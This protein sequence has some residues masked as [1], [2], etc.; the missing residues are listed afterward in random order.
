MNATASFNTI[1]SLL[2]PSDSAPGSLGGIVYYPGGTYHSIGRS[3]YPINVGL[4]P[5]ATSGASGATNGV[6]YFPTYSIWL[7]NGYGAPPTSTG[8]ISS[9]L[10]AEQLISYNSFVD[11]TSKTVMVSEWQKGT[12]IQP[13]VP[14]GSSTLGNVF[15]I[16]DTSTT[17]TGT[18]SPNQASQPYPDYA[19]AQD[20]Q[21]QTPNASQW[22]WKGDWWIL[23]LA[24]LTLTLSCRIGI[25]AGIPISARGREPS[26]WSLPHRIIRE[27]STRCS[28]TDLCDSSKARFLPRYGMRS[29][30]L[31]DVRPSTW[32]DCDEI[33]R[34]EIGPAPPAGVVR[35]SHLNR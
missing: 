11:G 10:Q 12:G 33:G 4:N 25:R 19:Y 18:I 14:A 13:P 31:A 28:P 27:A 29:R 34:A 8:S 1:Q 16:T 17:Y 22:T 20:C 2:C 26:R 5:Y 6:A 3:N 24:S 35:L 15:T 30:L 7:V 21:N 9:S 23:A 32:R